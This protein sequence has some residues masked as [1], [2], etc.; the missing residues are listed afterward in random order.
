[1]ACK[2]EKS[3]H[4]SITT[5]WGDTLDTSGKITGDTSKTFSVSDLVENGELIMLTEDGPQTYY[6]YHGC[7]LGVQ[8]LLVESFAEKLGVRVRVELCKDSADMVRR[9]KN[10][11]GDIVAFD[12]PGKFRAS[13]AELQKLIKKWNTLSL[14]NQISNRERQIIASGGVKRKIYSPYRDPEGGVISEYDRFFKQYARQAGW[15]WRLVAAQC[16]Q[17]STFDPQA[18]SFAGAKGLMQIMPKTAT[19]LG[20]APDEVYDPEKS[21]AAACRYLAELSNSFRDISDNYERQ[22]F[23]LASYNGG[24]GHIRDAM[25]LAQA[26]GKNPHSWG[27][28]KEYVLLLST[29]AGYRNPIVKHGYI[30]GSET[31]GYVDKIRRRYATYGGENNASGRSYSQP[32]PA[33][34]SIRVF[35]PT[36]TPQ[37]AGTDNTKATTD[38]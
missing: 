9:L 8:Y 31:V 14:L 6:E 34:A 36:A 30:R 3:R 17:E 4:D 19:H 27:D 37:R 38:K 10:N 32:K 23:V 2:D 25:A 16:Y 18:V 20:L 1:M 12:S 22:N 5:P 29:P 24:A 21:I 33:E 13:N 35:N 11:E 15:D 26:D 7:H 28:V